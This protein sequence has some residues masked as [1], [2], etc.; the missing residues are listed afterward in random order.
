MR[1]NAFLMNALKVVDL[2]NNF[3]SDSACYSF[4]AMCPCRFF[5]ELEW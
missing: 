5:L 2:L 4:E 1:G 3:Q